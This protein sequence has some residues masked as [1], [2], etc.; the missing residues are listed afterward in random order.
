M[1][2]TP[3]S[4][5]ALPRRTVPVWVVPSLIFVFLGVSVAFH[6]AAI[7]LAGT[8]PSVAV[9]P[10]YFEQGQSWDR[11]QAQ[12]AASQGAEPPV[13]YLYR[14]RRI[15]VYLRRRRSCHPYYYI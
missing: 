6:A 10:D 14:Y 9:V 3:A 1:T 8:D 13:I 4:P 2:E 12:Q 11:R 15:N 7:V 5:T